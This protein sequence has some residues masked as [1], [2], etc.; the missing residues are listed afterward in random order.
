MTADLRVRLLKISA[1]RCNVVFSLSTLRLVKKASA[2]TVVLANVRRHRSNMRPFFC[3][4]MDSINYVE[5]SEVRRYSLNDQNAG[6]KCLF[7]VAALPLSA[8]VLS[9][10]PCSL[11]WLN[12]VDE[13]A[14][15][16]VGFLLPFAA[17]AVRN[18]WAMGSNG[19]TVQHVSQQNEWKCH[20][21]QLRQL[22]EI[23]LI[24]ND[25]CYWECDTIA[26]ASFIF[27]VFKLVK[28][29]G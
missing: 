8:C 12:I 3:F 29:T 11:R 18:L 1:T 4:G 6:K 2:A 9:C 10:L 26:M 20:G 25:L 22:L 24:C 19:S 16:G 7:Q 27:F 13:F 21:S 15:Q 17:I 28:S 23:F 14:H 5:G